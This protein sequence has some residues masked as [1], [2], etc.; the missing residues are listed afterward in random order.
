V[1]LHGSA[2]IIQQRGA[3]P[4]A[5]LFYGGNQ[6][7]PFISSD[8]WIVPGGAYIRSIP[9][10]QLGGLAQQGSLGGTNFYSANLTVAKVLWG[11]PLMP[12]EF[13]QEPDFVNVLN[14]AVN[15]AKGSLQDYYK[16]NDPSAKAAYAEAAAKLDGIASAASQLTDT[17]SGLPGDISSDHVVAASLRTIRSE[18]RKTRQIVDALKKGDNNNQYPALLKHMSV[19][20]SEMTN[21]ARLLAEKSQAQT[22][23]TVSTLRDSLQTLGSNIKQDLSQIDS[24]AAE[25]RAAEEFAPAQKVLH[26]FLYELNTYSIAPVG[27][28]DIARVWPIG[29]GT[30]YGAGGGVRLSL[31]NV[32][33][34]LAYA[35]NPVRS[36]GEGRGA[37]FLKLDVEDLFH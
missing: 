33:L 37:F 23:A 16:A 19:L 3:V 29:V 12:K 27:I 4:A 13:A 9:Q 28:F 26:A 14:G 8:S 11:R 36:A 35:A 22:A 10:N 32:N 1:E 7:Q 17:I 24:K 5:E 25:K 18:V 30:R 15:T 31:V 2:G 6:V 34:T 20:A 21:L